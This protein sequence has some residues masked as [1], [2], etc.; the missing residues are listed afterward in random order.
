MRNSESDWLQ[1]KASK[2]KSGLEEGK[3][4]PIGE[5]KLIFTAEMFVQPYFKT[6][7]P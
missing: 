3:R 6:L 7:R 2:G 4:R 1:Y 5:K